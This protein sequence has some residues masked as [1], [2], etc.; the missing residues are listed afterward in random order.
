MY[1][2]VIEQQRETIRI[3]QQLLQKAT[4]PRDDGYDHNIT[5]GQC[6]EEYKNYIKRHSKPSSIYNVTWQIDHM[7]VLSNFGECKVDDTKRSE[8]QKWVDELAE[9]YATKTV[10]DAG[11]LINTIL[12]YAAKADLIPAKSFSI[13][14]P[15][16]NEQQ[17]YRVLTKKEF[18]KL[19][20]M[21]ID[22]E[23]AASTG[24]L[25][26]LETG[27]RIGEACGLQ[28]KDVDFRK[29]RVSVNKTVYRAG[30]KIYIGPPKTPSSNRVIPMTETLYETLKERRQE[31][32]LYIAT[33]KESFTEPHTLRTALTRRLK[34]WGIEHINPHGLRHSFATRA[35]ENGVDPKT[36]AA[37]LGH[38]NCSI[39][40]DVYTNATDRMLSNA[41]KKMN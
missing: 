38:K 35:I 11:S 29:R 36:V 12:K 6:A 33:N 3:L 17:E 16:E 22:D 39:T 10:R 15:K 32:E 40:L 2:E 21:L 28:W 25:V 18:N 7:G 8:I 23:S 27:M 26:M 5:F 1:E 14:Y 37:M 31:P 41:I 20:V 34:K 30:G 4:A 19:R 24:I 13:D 9:R